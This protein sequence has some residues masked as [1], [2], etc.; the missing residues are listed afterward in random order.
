MVNVLCA[1][2]EETEIK[3]LV[4]DTSAQGKNKPLNVSSWPLGANFSDLNDFKIKTP[5]DEL[6]EWGNNSGQHPPSEHWQCC[7]TR[8]C[9]AD[10]L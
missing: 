9:T 5:L 1:N 2:V 8:N 4:Y 7:C 6:F 10:G 3:N